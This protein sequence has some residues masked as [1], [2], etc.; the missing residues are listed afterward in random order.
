[1]RGMRSQLRNRN[2]LHTTHVE[3]FKKWLAELPGYEILPPTK[4]A[5]EV[6]RFRRIS[7]SGSEPDIFIYRNDHN[8]HL[9]VMAEA[10]PLVALFL[11]ERKSRK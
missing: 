8:D 4:H 7:K 5:Y 11:T 9:T 10:V 3:A 2:T 6:L 1:M